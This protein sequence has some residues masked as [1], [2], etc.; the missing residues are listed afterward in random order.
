[1]CGASGHLS[2]TCPDNP[3]RLYADGGSCKLC[4]SVEHYKKDC[5]ERKI[6]D[7]V[8]AYRMNDSKIKGKHLSLDDEL[9]LYEDVS[10]NPIEKPPQPVKKKPKTVNF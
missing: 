1:M 3:R 7:E 9:T 2:N 4:G 10:E 5:P 6:H 8:H